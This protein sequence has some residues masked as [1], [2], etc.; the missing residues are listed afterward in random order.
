MSQA[1]DR[2]VVHL[3]RHGEVHNPEKVLY[4][5]L[6]GYKLSDLGHRMAVR[7]DKTQRVAHGSCSYGRHRFGRARD[8]DDDARLD[9]TR[10]H[11][12]RVFVARADDDRATR[13]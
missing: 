10:S 5:R 12:C 1:D 4:G 7:L 3:L 11:R 9:R 2:T 6:P 8:V 13:R